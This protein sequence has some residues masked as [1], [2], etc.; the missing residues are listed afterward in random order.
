M[1]KRRA[2]DSLS[3]ALI[4]L[5]ARGEP[6]V[7]ATA[8]LQYSNGLVRFH[9]AHPDRFVQFGISEQNMVS[10][11]AGMAAAGMMPY[12]ATFA[13]FLAFSAASRSAW[14]SPIRPYRFG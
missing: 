8:D 9:E 4:E 11:A 2:F 14:T 5:V 10:A 13:S 3:D 6:V 7:A 1:P 12:V